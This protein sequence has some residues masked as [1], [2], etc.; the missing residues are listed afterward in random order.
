MYKFGFPLLLLLGAPFR[1]GAL[2]RDVRLSCGA[3]LTVRLGIAQIEFNYSVPL[4]ACAADRC[5]SVY[6][7]VLW[8]TLHCEYFPTH[9][10]TPLIPLSTILLLMSAIYHPCNPF[11]YASLSPL[12]SPSPF[13]L[14]LTL[15]SHSHPPLS[16]SLPF[17]VSHQGFSLVLEWKCCSCVYSLGSIVLLFCV[18]IQ[19]EITQVIMVRERKVT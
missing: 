17:S 12:P 1:I 3:G 7:Y 2:M 10:S 6:M 19:L 13:P 18:F 5:V 16:P 4:K 14:P 15:P 8:L 11:S 9:F